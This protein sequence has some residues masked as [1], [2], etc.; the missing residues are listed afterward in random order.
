MEPM[1]YTWLFVLGLIFAFADA[2]GI[3]SNDVAN[4]FATSVGSR[5]LTLKKALSIAV[6]TELGGAVL[7]GAGV[8][9]TIKNKIIDLKLFADKPEAL[10]LAFVCALFGSALWVNAASRFGLPVS[11]THSIVGAVA[12]VGLAAFGGDAV[13][14]GWAG[15]GKIIA[16]WFISPVVAGLVAS[17]IYLITKFGV[18]RSP[19]ALSRGLLAVPVYIFIT[20]FVCILYIVLKGGKSK[21][22]SKNMGIAIGVAAGVGGAVAIWAI[23]FYVSWLRRLLV[24]EENMR[25]YHVF[26]TPFVPTQPKDENFGNHLDSV[27]RDHATGP[28]EGPKVADPET[29]KVN[30]SA[31]LETIDANPAQ[32]TS[33]LAVIDEKSK[34][35]MFG[36]IKDMLMDNVNRDVVTSQNA[37]VKHVHDH[38]VKY[39]SKVEYLYAFVQTLTASF[40][41][42]AHGSNDVANAVGP[43]AAIYAI[44]DSGILPKSN[45]DVPIWILFFGGVAID[46]GFLFCGW[47]VMRNLG[48]NITYH[49]PSRGFSMELGAAITVISASYINLPVSTTHCITGAT[50]FVGLCNGSA[51]AVNWKV[52]AWCFGG[53]IVTVPVAGLVS[54]GLFALLSNAPKLY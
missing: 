1:T 24:N 4:S 46:L 53:W 26:Y 36:S 25:W 28:A 43:L 54:G 48:N 39:E 29:G 40:A 16:S 7:L 21:Q 44:W 8:A 34:R 6:F 17:I 52:L 3:G 42:F 32:A 11:T 13:L 19:K 18:L 45:V 2:F 30:H 41:S 22:L 12:G 27:Y 15:M 5:S 31:S 47:R 51:K 38:A 10:M 33:P 9:D 50:A 37:N 20:L 49:S 35:G 14:W 23:I